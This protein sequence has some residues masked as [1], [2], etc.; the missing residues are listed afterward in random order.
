MQLLLKKRYVFSRSLCAFLVLTSVGLCMSQTTSRIHPDS[1]SRITPV[2][3]DD[4]APEHKHIYDRVLGADR[5][6]P[7]Y[8]PGGVSI[9]M[10]RVADAMDIL[11]QYLRYDSVIGRRYIEVAILVAAREFDQAYEWA[12][13]EPAALAEGTPEAVVDAIKFKNS[14][15]DLPV[16]DKVIIDY[17]R[18]IMREHRLDQSLW[19]AAVNEF[20][21]QGALEIAAIIGDYL[22]AAVLLHAVDQQIPPERQDTLPREY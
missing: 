1:L 20:G 13:H 17:G 15:E 12:A 19:D 8:G 7:M 4:V 11:N 10:P 6:T 5:T 2:Y 9:H 3:R 22:L 14:T 16:K 21:Q 18:Q